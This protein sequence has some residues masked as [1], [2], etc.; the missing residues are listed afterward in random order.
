MAHN[1]IIISS[2]SSSSDGSLETLSVESY[3]S[4][5]KQIPTKTVMLYNKSSTFLPHR[6]QTTLW[7]NLHMTH[8]INVQGKKLQ[9]T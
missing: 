5:I 8:L 1:T 3:G 6:F 7:K 4:G 9:R 2:E